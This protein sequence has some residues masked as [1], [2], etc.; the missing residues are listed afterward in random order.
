MQCSINT[1]I[2]MHIAVCVITPKLLFMQTNLDPENIQVSFV[3]ILLI[4]L[5]WADTSPEN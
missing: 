1:S 5:L 3:A 2:Y 4:E